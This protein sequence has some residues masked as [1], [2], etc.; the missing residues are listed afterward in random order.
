MVRPQDPGS[1]V[2]SGRAQCTK[3]SHEGEGRQRPA[4]KGKDVKGPAAGVEKGACLTVVGLVMCK[5]LSTKV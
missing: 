2:V 1:L 4:M 3:A 5:V